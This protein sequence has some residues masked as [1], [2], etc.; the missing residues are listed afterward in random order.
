VNIIGLLVIKIEMERVSLIIAVDFDGTCVD[1]IFPLI[2]KDVPDAVRVLKRLSD[3]GHRI[4]LW[5]MRAD[6]SNHPY[7]LLD[8]VKW[9]EDRGIPLWGVNLN[10][11]QG[12]SH[13]KKQY[14]NYYIDDAAVGCPLI[15]LPS[16]E[17]SM[18]NWQLI[19]KFFA[20]KEFFYSSTD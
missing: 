17:R 18:V 11:E 13:S 7:V 16:F 12:W 15:T 14:A 1:H 3:S 2:G 19:E 20:E 10:P 5:T 4:M 6:G 9:F 8:A